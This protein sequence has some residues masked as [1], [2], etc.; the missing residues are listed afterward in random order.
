MPVDG[1]LSRHDGRV[2]AEIL[3]ERTLGFIAEVA[4]PTKPA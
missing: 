2:D 4:A 3:A 1:G